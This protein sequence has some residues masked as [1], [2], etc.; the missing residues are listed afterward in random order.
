VAPYRKGLHQTRIWLQRAGPK[1]FLK[2]FKNR[3]RA[4]DRRHVGSQQGCS[5]VP[6]QFNRPSRRLIS[7][8]I[9]DLAVPL[10]RAADAAQAWRDHSLLSGRAHRALV[11]QLR[12][13]IRAL[14][15]IHCIEDQASFVAP[16]PR[17]H[18]QVWI[19]DEKDKDKPAQIYVLIQ[20]LGI[21]NGMVPHIS[22]IIEPLAVSA[23]A[24]IS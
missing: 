2:N 24:P 10:C 17:C 12:Y 9:A 19:T 5:S 4:V 8:V 14:Q 3:F 16:L 15:S 7:K 11:H 20:T 23:E 6:N 22:T 13:P 18:H 1:K 21:W